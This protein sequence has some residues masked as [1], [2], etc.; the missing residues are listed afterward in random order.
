MI[1]CFS[2]DSTIKNLAQWKYCNAFEISKA[3]LISDLGQLIKPDGFLPQA[4]TDVWKHARA[5]T[6][7]SSVVI[8]A[9]RK[10]V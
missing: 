7:T 1:I 9:F 2:A 10:L 8:V 5:Y 6:D 3:D 4:C